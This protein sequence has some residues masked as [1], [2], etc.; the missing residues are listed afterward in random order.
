MQNTIAIVMSKIVPKHR[1]DNIFD[2]E[3]SR[4]IKSHAL[5]TCL[6]CIAVAVKCLDG[7]ILHY[8]KNRFLSLIYIKS[9]RDREMK[10]VSLNWAGKIWSICFFYKLNFDHF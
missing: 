8:F 7:K 5:K 9:A 2:G 4:D 6:E 1:S 10:T 3:R